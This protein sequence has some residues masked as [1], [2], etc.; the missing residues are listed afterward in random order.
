MQK[1]AFLAPFLLSYKIFD[2]T[3]ILLIGFTNGVF[4]KTIY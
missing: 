3:L 2:I 1:G 4:A